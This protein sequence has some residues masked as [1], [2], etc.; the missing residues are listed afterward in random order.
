MR[1]SV[2]GFNVAKN[3]LFLSCGK[4]AHALTL[5][6]RMHWCPAL[7]PVLA[8]ACLG[9]FLLFHREELRHSES[10]LRSP[11][12][13]WLKAIPHWPAWPP[14][15]SLCVPCALAYD[16]RA[17][18]GA[19]PGC[20]TACPQWHSSEQIS[21]W[22]SICQASG[23]PLGAFLGQGSNHCCLSKQNQHSKS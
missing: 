16:A 1:L 15:N 6:L 17:V 3:P 5:V 13:E 23:I 11:P 7:L 22:L 9:W 4:V 20:Y 12:P 10:A 14:E 18:A 19:G 21:C 2:N 8:Q